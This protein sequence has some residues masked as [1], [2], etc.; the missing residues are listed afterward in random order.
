MNAQTA[1]IT[2]P[3][4]SAAELNERVVRRSAVEVVVGSI[5]ASVY[6]G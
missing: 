1:G 5:P 4:F 6:L 2:A 3:A